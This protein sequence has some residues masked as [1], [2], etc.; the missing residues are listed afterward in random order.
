MGERADGL[1]GLVINENGRIPEAEKTFRHYESVLYAFYNRELTI[2]SSDVVTALQDCDDL[3]QISDYL[4]CTSLVCKPI[5]IALFRHGQSL[6]PWIQKTPHL[7]I[8]LASRIRSE[9]LFRECMIHLVGNWGV[10]RNNPQVSKRLRLLPGMRALIE[11]Y[12][13]AL[14]KKGEELELVVMACYPGDMASPSDDLP[15]KRE[16]YARDILIWMALTFFRHW[17]AHRLLSNKGRH[18]PDS[19]YELYK[20]LGTGGEAYMD[21]LV[22]LQF[23]K[24]FPVTSKALNV[25]GAHVDEIKDVVVDMVRKHGILKSECSLDLQRFPVPYLTC[26]EFKTADLP[27]L[28]EA[29]SAAVPAK[30]EYEPGGNDIARE[31]LE[32]AK[33]LQARR[34]ASMSEHAEGESEGEDGE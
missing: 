19:G 7:Y 13:R 23:H 22:I 15:I 2:N 10:L 5:E 28:K 25:L 18:A 9:I 14:L 8:E 17:L 11:K 12:H 24:K 29:A 6:F 26:T 20:Q 4:G 32:A 3:L 31:N 1:I 34:S 21:R 16:A 27:W 30:R 33:R